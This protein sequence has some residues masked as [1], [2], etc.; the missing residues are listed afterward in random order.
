MNILIL[1]QPN[2]GKSSLFNLL[3][4]DKK[5]ITHSSLGTTRDWHVGNVKNLNG[6]FVY[7]T[8]GIVMKNDKIEILDFEKILKKVKIL[9]Y[10]IDYNS[11]NHSKD[12]AA[13]KK[14]RK[15]NKK[16]IIIIN[17]DDNKKN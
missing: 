5:N 9:F 13:L 17:K 15:F 14:L 10:V 16:C 3:T 1:G 2:V 4:N 8:P 6:I 7:D 11:N 12:S